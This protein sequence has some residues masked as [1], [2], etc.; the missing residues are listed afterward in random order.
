[1]LDA[2]VMIEEAE[3][4]LDSHYT[5]LCEQA[6]KQLQPRVQVYNAPPQPVGKQPSAPPASTTHLNELVTNLLM[7]LMLS[8]LNKGLLSR[9]SR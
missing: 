6:R 7:L 8:A 3:A 5:Q 4:L 1:M 9:P 2:N